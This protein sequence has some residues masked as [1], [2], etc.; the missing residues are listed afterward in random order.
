MGYF[1]KEIWDKNKKKNNLTLSI[2]LKGLLNI[3]IR[4][5]I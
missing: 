1:L 4:Q 2:I 3:C 5:K